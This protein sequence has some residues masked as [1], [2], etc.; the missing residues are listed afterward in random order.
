MGLGNRVVNKVVICLVC[1]ALVVGSNPVYGKSE[2][3]RA[4]VI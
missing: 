4:Y 3:L 2:V 1:T